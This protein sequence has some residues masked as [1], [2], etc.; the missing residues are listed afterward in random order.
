MSIDKSLPVGIAGT[1]AMAV[2]FAVLFSGNGYKTT[3]IGRSEASLNKMRDT[4]SGIFDVLEERKLV[5]AA[6]RKKCEA[7]ISYSTRFEDLS[8]AEM[9]FEAVYE[10]AGIKYEIFKKIQGLALFSQHAY[11]ILQRIINITVYFNLRRY[12]NF[13]LLISVINLFCDHSPGYFRE[14]VSE[15]F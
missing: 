10:E 11:R 7:L 3:A 2:G 9:V 14:T 6:Q 5:S 4:C 8:D 12:I 13:I 15:C 1:G